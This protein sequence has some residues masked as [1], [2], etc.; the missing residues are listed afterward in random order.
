MNKIKVKMEN[1]ATKNYRGKR[2]TTLWVKFVDFRKKNS[3][4][5]A[6]MLLEKAL[7]KSFFISF[8]WKPWKDQ[9][10][11]KRRSW[12]LQCHLS[13][14]TISKFQSCLQL[15]FFSKETSK[16]FRSRKFLET[17]LKLEWLKKTRLE[18]RS[19]KKRVFQAEW[20]QLNRIET[21]KTS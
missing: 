20:N 12:Q 14:E 3:Q 9:Q 21:I 11:K 2:K 10:M 1:W 17:M 6:K 13:K 5:N 19:W 8:L 15:F 7:W 4:K 18:T 16:T